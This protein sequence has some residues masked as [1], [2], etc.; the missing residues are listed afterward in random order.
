[1]NVDKT[2]WAVRTDG[3]VYS[4]EITT[5][6]LSGRSASYITYRLLNE[7]SDDTT[8]FTNEECARAYLADFIKEASE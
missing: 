7:S 1:M 3:K 8:Y 6:P 5:Q 2:I 4:I